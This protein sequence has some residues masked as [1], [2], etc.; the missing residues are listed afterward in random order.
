VKKL[1]FVLLTTLFLLACYP[2]LSIPPILRNPTEPLP[3]HGLSQSRADGKGGEIYNKYGLLGRKRVEM[4]DD[5]YIV[6][7]I[8]DASNQRLPAGVKQIYRNVTVDSVLDHIYL[9]NTVLNW[10]NLQDKMIEAQT[11]CKIPLHE[12]VIATKLNHYPEGSDKFSW[13]P[14]KPDYYALNFG[15]PQRVYKGKNLY[16]MRTNGG[17]IAMWEEA[18]LIYEDSMTLK[19]FYFCWIMAAVFLIISIVMN[20][21]NAVVRRVVSLFAFLA[22]MAGLIAILFGITATGGICF[23]FMML[24]MALAIAGAL[25]TRAHTAAYIV[26]LSLS[27]AGFLFLLIQS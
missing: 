21:R 5:H 4:Q 6:L 1:Y 18:T 17:V 27:L 26:S 24:A 19:F 13:V 12:Q 3:P 7:Q 2:L 16:A 9:Y 15:L 8:I 11:V 22:G 23:V 25:A 10:T 14:D 20:E